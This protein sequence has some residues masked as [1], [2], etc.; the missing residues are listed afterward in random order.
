ML[1]P[2]LFRCNLFSVV[3]LAVWKCELKRRS[4]FIHSLPRYYLSSKN[5]QDT[6]C[7]QN[8]FDNGPLQTD[9]LLLI[10]GFFSVSHKF[11]LSCLSDPVFDPNILRPHFLRWLYCNFKNM[12]GSRR[13][14]SIYIL[15]VDRDR[16]SL[17]FIFTTSSSC[18][19]LN[20]LLLYYRPV[21]GIYH[22]LWLHNF[23]HTVPTVLLLCARKPME[24]RGSGVII[25]T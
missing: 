18:S 19:K 11:C 16:F 23:V 4:I 17:C 13:F 10:L 20:V 6:C 8:E 15:V 25:N 1:W 24:Q 7:I 12:K 21:F 14:I 5:W 22:K 3:C 9:S 2:E